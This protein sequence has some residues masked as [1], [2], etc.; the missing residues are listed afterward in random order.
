MGRDKLKNPVIDFLDP[1]FK[2]FISYKCHFGGQIFIIF[3]DFGALKKPTVRDFF[4]PILT[5]WDRFCSYT[6]LSKN[7]PHK[8]HCAWA[9]TPPPEISIKFIENYDFYRK[10]G[11]QYSRKN[12]H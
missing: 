4:G 6:D 7:S 11:L 5:L 10:M 2:N 8:K 1:T 3:I 12:R 9:R